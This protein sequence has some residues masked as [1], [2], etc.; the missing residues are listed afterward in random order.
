MKLKFS[1]VDLFENKFVIN[2]RFQNQN[3]MQES[4]QKCMPLIVF[5]CSNSHNSFKV[6]F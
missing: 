2:L 3:F 4:L 5:I 1:Y 6:F